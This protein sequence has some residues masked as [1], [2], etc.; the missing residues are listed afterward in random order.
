MPAIPVRPQGLPRDATKGNEGNK[1]GSRSSF[2]S[3]PFV[4]VPG[5][6]PARPPPLSLPGPYTC[7]PCD[8]VNPTPDYETVL[9]H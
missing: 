3:F 4:G 7:Q 1:G 2:A 8:N 5:N 9:T 6:P